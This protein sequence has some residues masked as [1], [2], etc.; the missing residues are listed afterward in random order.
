MYPLFLYARHEP[1]SGIPF[2]TGC[3]PF[4]IPQNR[5][6]GMKPILNEGFSEKSC[7]LLLENSKGN[8][9][10][11]TKN[12]YSRSPLFFH[13]NFAN[14]PSYYLLGYQLLLHN[15]LKYDSCCF[16]LSFYHHASIMLFT[17]WFT[18]MIDNGLF[19]FI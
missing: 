19:A 7:L 11:R 12:Y 14:Q 3:R 9:G 2:D 6:D 18:Y 13:E 17:C 1:L 10:N 5:S 16:P 4:D 15:I 8:Q